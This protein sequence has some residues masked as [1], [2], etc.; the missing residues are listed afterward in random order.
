MFNKICST[1]LC[2]SLF[3]SAGS[4]AERVPA[5]M[6]VHPVERGG[7]FVKIPR[8]PR[9]EEEEAEEQRKLAESR[10]KAEEA[11][12]KKEQEEK[13]RNQGDKDG[14]NYKMSHPDEQQPD[15]TGKSDAYKEGYPEGYKRADLELNT[16][17]EQTGRMDGYH[18]AF[19]LE[20]DEWLPEIPENVKAEIY[21]KAYCEEFIQTEVAHKS[22]LTSEAYDKAYSDYIS[23]SKFPSKSSKSRSAKGDNYFQKYYVLGLKEAETQIETLKTAVEIQG[24]ADGHQRAEK[25]DSLYKDL[26][27]VGNPTYKELDAI[28]DEAYQQAKLE[29]DLKIFGAIASALAAAL[30]GGYFLKRRRKAYTI[31]PALKK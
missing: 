21:R 6:H 29:E 12:L 17:S 10:K 8:E 1:I 5:T 24:A 2:C 16:I 27:G 9:S 22:E 28:Y 30:L 3:L 14:Y 23:K 31:D 20:Q 13:E 4:A 19:K 15:L 26:Q 18:D 11:R 25:S 7:G